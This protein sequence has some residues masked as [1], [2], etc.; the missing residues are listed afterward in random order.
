MHFLFIY[1]FIFTFLFCYFVLKKTQ[2]HQT[3]HSNYNSSH[4]YY[5]SIHKYHKLYTILFCYF[6]SHKIHF[7]KL[8]KTLTFTN[9]PKMHISLPFHFLHHNLCIYLES[10]SHITLHHYPTHHHSPPKNHPKKVTKNS[11][12]TKIPNY[13]FLLPT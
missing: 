1:L 11:F 12:F 13:P 3:K 6:Q 8:K 2:F 4:F 7:Q 9:S 10:S 5:I